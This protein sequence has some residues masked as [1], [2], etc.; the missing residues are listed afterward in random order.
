MVIYEER[1]EL[2]VGNVWETI[3]IFEYI[4]MPTARQLRVTSDNKGNEMTPYFVMCLVM[5]KNTI[6]FLLKTF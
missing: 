6:L 3:L 4:K 5:A 1:G 2:Q